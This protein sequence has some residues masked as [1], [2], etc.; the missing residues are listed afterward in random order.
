MATPV[1]PAPRDPN[2]PDLWDWSVG[3]DDDGEEPAVRRHPGR[4]VLAAILVVAL[5]AVFVVSYAS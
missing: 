1:G 2:D 3:D 5:V 4:A